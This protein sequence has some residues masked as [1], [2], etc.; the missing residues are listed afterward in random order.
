MK[1]F[2][3]TIL[4]A[5]G[6]VMLQLTLNPSGS[7]NTLHAENS[8]V[9]LRHADI[10][11]GG[12]DAV[13]PYRAAIGNVVMVKGEMTMTCRRTTDYDGQNRIIMNGDVS[14]S[15][16]SMEVFGDDGVFYPKREVLELS[17]NVR[18]RMKDNSLAV[19]SKKGMFNNEENQ[20]WFYDNAVGWKGKDQVSGEII[21]LHFR[22]SEKKG[23]KQTID[24]M[25]LHGNAFYAS[26]DTLIHSPVGYDQMS[27]KKIVALIGENSRMKDL[28]VTGQ[29]E[30]LF[31]LYDEN[32]KPSGI[33]YSSGDRIKMFFREGRMHKMKVTGN[34]EGT[35]YPAS[36]RGEASINLPKFVWGEAENPWARPEIQAKKE[37]AEKTKVPE[38]EGLFDMEK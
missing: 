27:G 24:E 37:G 11:E 35:E 33:N 6:I 9:I 19:R 28:T 32:S 34:A 17:G 12:E 5:A 30:S 36:F 31:H 23:G 15:D 25:Q 10:I 16:G 3:S 26:P 8:K 29:A 7:N 14:I 38:F 21:L 20:L 4:L 22:K 2:F 13:G 18:G 1:R